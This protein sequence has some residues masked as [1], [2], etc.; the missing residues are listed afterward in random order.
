[1]TTAADTNAEL[2]ALRA[3]V[4]DLRAGPPDELP[5]VL[6]DRSGRQA[7]NPDALGQNWFALPLDTS[8]LAVPASGEAL[9]GWTIPEDSGY[10]GDFEVAGLVGYGVAPFTVELS[11]VGVE[12]NAFANAPIHHSFCTGRGGLPCVFA[13]TVLLEPNT[14]VTARVVNLSTVL[15]NSVRLVFVGRK[16]NSSMRP[17]E[18]ERIARFLL[19]RPSRPFWAV[20][21]RGPVTLTA[22]QQRVESYITIPSG[23][24]FTAESLLASSTGPFSVDIYDA[25]SGRQLT[26]GAIDSRLITGFGG[27]PAR[28]I[29]A[30]LI[31]PRRALRVYFTDLSGE[32]NTIYFGLHGRRVHLPLAA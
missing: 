31:Q 32:G 15:Q 9:S 16:L 29:G 8:P 27:L 13:E 17:E 2:E 1:M 28:T 10:A 14:T 12:A 19:S 6:V 25:Q 21:D 7:I 4:E 3:E 24:H 22:G 26:Y 18:R 23:S 5:L 20:L 11:L 30:P